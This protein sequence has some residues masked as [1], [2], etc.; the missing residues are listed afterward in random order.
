MLARLDPGG[1][2]DKGVCAIEFGDDP[3]ALCA[4]CRTALPMRGWWR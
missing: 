3:D 1:G 2:T 4:A